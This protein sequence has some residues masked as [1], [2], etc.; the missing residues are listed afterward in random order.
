M[1]T[2]RRPPRYRKL[3]VLAL[4]FSLFVHFFGGYLF[5]R[6]WRVAGSIAE[7][8]APKG[9]RSEVSRITI[10]KRET[11]EPAAT[12][13]PVTKPEPV[14][15][16][17]PDLPKPKVLVPPPPAAAPRHSAARSLPKTHHELAHIVVH[18]PQQSAKSQREGAPQQSTLSND[19]IAQIESKFSKTIADSRTDIKT[20]TQQVQDSQPAQPK[21][22]TMQFNGIHSDMRKGDG[23]IR[24]TSVGKRVGNLVY[25]YTRYEYMYAD[26]H[27]E[28]DD[29]PWIFAYP[30]NDDPFTNGAYPGRRLPIQPPPPGYRPTRQLQPILMQFFGGPPVEP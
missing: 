8:D 4:A 11:P 19:Q 15:P 12:A 26:G 29:I 28:Q 10:E 1:I 21:H 2:S 13:P 25:Y 7:V 3:L 23:T 18:A 9:E 14:V 30:I 27:V 22:Y 6:I 24:P 16:E 17:I 5:T 20:V